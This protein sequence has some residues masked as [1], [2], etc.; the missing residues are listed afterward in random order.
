MPLRTHISIHAPL[1]GSDV[2]GNEIVDDWLISIHAPLAGSDLRKEALTQG[3][4]L[5]Q[6]TLPLRGATATAVPCPTTILFQSTLPL[7][8]ATMYE[9]GKQEPNFISIHAPLAGSDGSPGRV[10]HKFSHF[11]PR[12]PCGERPLLFREDPQPKNFN[13]RSP[14]GERRQ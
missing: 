2:D 13:P 4:P 9:S 10:P 8:G 1:A 11:N 7:R 5:F 12:S 6:S 3:V 14:C